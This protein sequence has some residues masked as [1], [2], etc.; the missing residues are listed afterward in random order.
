MAQDYLT[1]INT[2][3]VYDIAQVSPLD[4]APLLSKKLHN[5]ILLK[6]E[7]LQP[8]FSFKLR[9]AY[10]KIASL[11]SADRTAGIIAASA[12][13]HAQGVALAGQRLGI[14]TMIVMPRTTPQIKVAAVRQRGAK[15]VL[16]GDTYDQACQHALDVAAEIKHV[17]IHPYDDVE[18]IAGQGTIGKE[19]HEQYAQEIAAVFIPVGGGGLIAGI[20]AYL[21]AYRPATK[22]IGVEPEDAPTLYAAMQAGKRVTLEQVG[23]FADGVAV[24]QIGA[25]PFRVARYLVDEVVLVNTDQICAA[26]K[27]NFDETRVVAEP[28]GALA[29]AGMKKYAD[30]H[31]LTDCN[32]VALISGANINFDRLAHI[33]ERYE[34]GE[35]TESLFAVTIPEQP[36]SFLEFCRLLESRTITEFNYR[37]TDATDAHVFVGL[38]F[39]NA[40]QEKD[41]LI[42]RLRRNGYAVLDISE[43]E[44]AKLHLRHMVGGCPQGLT[45]ER[46]F[47]FQFPERPGALLEF[48][49][50]MQRDWNISLFHYRNHG[51]AY[52]RVLA[53]IQVPDE[54]L[55][56]LSAFIK[57]V[58]YRHQS[59]SD[60]PAY[61]LFLRS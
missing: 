58:G 47:R 26:I 28:A 7:D 23:L 32:L 33:V 46:L 35:N 41:A 56:E 48:L 9:G 44:M 29:I 25:E 5:R 50:K 54:A 12:G 27:D 51:S 38:K 24:S 59:E 57:Q 14:R 18:V 34:V 1:K 10:N 16:L 22:I 19:L 49:E 31:K 36:G 53:G 3:K 20:A 52:G 15:V 8:I 17:F 37:Y 61:P 45:D 30:E 13:N 60:N 55:A 2:A 4:V 6:R 40:A 39:A 42:E 43:N 21:K 11:S